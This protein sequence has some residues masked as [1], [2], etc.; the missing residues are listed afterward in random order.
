MPANSR[1]W[2]TL[3]I[4][5]GLLAGHAVAAPPLEGS[6]WQ[7]R[8][9]AS[10]DGAPGRTEIAVPAVFTLA[11]GADGAAFF[12][13]DC[14]RGRGA[15]KAAPSS[16]PSAGVLEFG[17]LAT[18]RMACPPGSLDQRVMRDLAL[19]RS[20]RLKDGVLYLSLMDDGGVY[21]WTPVAAVA[22]VR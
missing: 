13:I 8:A 10:T 11:F 3:G 18:T 12:R 9:I 19:V 7:L 5:V 21:E 14:N 20:Y 15:W 6:A 17:P 16:D 22:G 2:K 1:A 4:A